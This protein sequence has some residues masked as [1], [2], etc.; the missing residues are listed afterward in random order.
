M[1]KDQT[2]IKDDLFYHICMNDLICSMLSYLIL[3]VS[4]IY[5]LINAALLS[6]TLFLTLFK[7]VA[8]GREIPVMD[9]DDLSS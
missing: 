2:G 5:L 8:D 7:R 4:N 6:I 1:K 9:V 3:G